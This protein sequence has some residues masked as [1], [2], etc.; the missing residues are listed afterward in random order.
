[1]SIR[2]TNPF[3]PGDRA[4]HKSNQ[5]DSREVAEVSGAMIRLVIGSVPDCW[6]PAAN[7]DKVGEKP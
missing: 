4:L 6:V 1:M 3:K 2:P 5:L 7:Y